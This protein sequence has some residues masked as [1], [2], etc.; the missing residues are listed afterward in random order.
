MSAVEVI[1]TIT[2][3]QYIQLYLTTTSQLKDSINVR[4]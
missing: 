2:T 1:F 4:S 3:E